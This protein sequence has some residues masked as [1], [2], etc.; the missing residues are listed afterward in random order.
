MH[1]LFP[2][3]LEDESKIV[4]YLAQQGCWSSSEIQG[5]SKSTPPPSEPTSEL[6]W[7]IAR[8]QKSPTKI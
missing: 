4:T 5:T 8:H 6:C 2:I 1:F 3:F 7:R